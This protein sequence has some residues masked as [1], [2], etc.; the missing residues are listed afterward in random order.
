MPFYFRVA[1]DDRRLESHCFDITEADYADFILEKSFEQFVIG[2][3]VCQNPVPEAFPRPFLLVVETV[4]ALV[5]AEFL[6]FPAIKLPAA[7]EAGLLLPVILVF[8]LFLF[9]TKMPIP[10]QRNKES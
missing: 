2:A 8:H 7:L 10:F 5:A 4:F 9:C 6:V 3:Q 1:C